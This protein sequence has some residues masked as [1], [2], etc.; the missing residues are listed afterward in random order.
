MVIPTSSLSRFP[1]FNDWNIA[2]ISEIINLIVFAEN[3][4]C[5]RNTTL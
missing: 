1:F 2:L 5:I 4:F 3:M